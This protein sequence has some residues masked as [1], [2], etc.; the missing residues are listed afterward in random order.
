MKK[1]ASDSKRQKQEIDA[2][3]KTT[4]PISSYNGAQIFYLNWFL[5][6]VFKHIEQRIKE[7]IRLYTLNVSAIYVKSDRD[8]KQQPTWEQT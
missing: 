6:H 1:Q 4:D 2:S 8:D 5:N 7:S 3:H